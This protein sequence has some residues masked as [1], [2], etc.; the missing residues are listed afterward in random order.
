[1]DRPTSIPQ[2]IWDSFSDKARAVVRAVIDG[3]ERQV[4]ELRQQ[5]RDLKAR[6]DQNSTNSS[7]SP[8]TDPID[9]KRRPPTP[10]S[11]KRVRS[12]NRAHAAP[13]GTRTGRRQGV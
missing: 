6:L 5:V 4:S 11:K 8:S 10:P 9:A 1:M 12:A 7:K 13:W 3:L 2:H